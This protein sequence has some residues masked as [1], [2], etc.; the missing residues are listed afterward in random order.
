MS[1]YKRNK[2]WYY[3][4]CIRGVRYGNAVPEA[5][6]KWQ[7][8]QA[9]ARAKDEVFSGRYGDSQSNVTLK[10]FVENQFLPWSKDNKRSWKDDVARCKAILAYFKNKKM[11]EISRF[12]VEQFKRSGLPRPLKVVSVALLPRLTVKFNCFLAFLI[13]QLSVAKFKPTPV[14]GSN[15]F[16]ST[17]K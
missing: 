17:T 14:K 16:A 13:W 8:E 1:V 12:N 5:R 10:E 4:F 15:F 6:T 3:R 2:V 11:R 9:E 7:A